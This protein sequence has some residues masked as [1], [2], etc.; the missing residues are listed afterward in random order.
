MK[1]VFIGGSRAVSKINATIRER[2]TNIISREIAVIVGDAN[3]ADK[4]VQRFFAD[5]SYINVTVYCMNSPR[6]NLGAWPV[7]TFVANSS[8]RD[9][10][11][12]AVKDRAMAEEANCGFMLWDG[13]S[14][15]TLSNIN[16]LLSNNKTVLVYFSPN[17]DFWKVKSFSDLR[18]ALESVGIS[19]VGSIQGTPKPQQLL[20]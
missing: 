20:P 19:G 17:H 5:H 6:N 7:R 3:G 11:Y 12:Y 10:H 1:T 4:A 14:R 8:R 2:L 15:G 16:N 18:L 13:V 9:F